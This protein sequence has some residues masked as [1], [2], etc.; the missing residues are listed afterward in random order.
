MQFFI[1]VILFCF[2]VFL[3]C[4]YA[5]SNDDLVLLRKD[6]S[7]EKIFNLVFLLALTGL[8]FARLFY[9]LLFSRNIFENFFK[10]FL[11]PYFPGLSLLGGVIGGILFLLIIRKKEIALD[12]LFDLFS[13][14][15]LSVL[16]FGYLGYFLLMKINLLTVESVFL[17]TVYIVAF[18]FFILYLF[19]RLLKSSF[20]EG[21]IGFLFL[22]VYSSVSLVNNYLER[23]TI[24]WHVDDFI[25]L[26][27]LLIS[28]VYLIDK[29]DL[30]ERIKKKFKFKK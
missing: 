22:I 28:L 11:F 3:F 12:R 21:T 29:G 13:I 8:F 20:K 16:P 23:T 30:P 7:T 27:I 17:I 24:F 9:G 25:L 2:F 18:L 1:L 26:L 14:S 19:P 10:F 6:V 5:L 4:L 15:F